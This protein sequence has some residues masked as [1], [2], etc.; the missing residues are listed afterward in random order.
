MQKVF[1]PKEMNLG[2]LFAHAFI[3]L[4]L[5]LGIA[6]FFIMGTGEPDPAWD[7]P[8]WVRPLIVLCFAG[9]CAGT[10]FFLLRNQF[11]TGGSRI[12]A[13]AIAVLIAIVG[14]WMGMVIGFVG[15]LWH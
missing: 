3:G 8:W 1:Y 13:T 7:K 12:I 9:T 2:S 15:T 6:M 14:L 5:G 11:R 4:L 10:Q